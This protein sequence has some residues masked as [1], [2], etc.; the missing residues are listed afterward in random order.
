MDLLTFTCPK[1]PIWNNSFNMAWAAE[2]SNSFKN[3]I[4]Y[5]MWTHRTHCTFASVCKQLNFMPVSLY[6][7]HT[8]SFCHRQTHINTYTPR[9]GRFGVAGFTAKAPPGS[10]DKPRLLRGMLRAEIG[11]IFIIRM[12]CA[13]RKNNGYTE[14][15]C[16]CATPT[17]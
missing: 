15:V 1:M 16:D 2:M 7:W 11:T 4:K 12:W 13:F 9:P 14:T 5:Y 3:S 10:T 6:T 17:T 8:L